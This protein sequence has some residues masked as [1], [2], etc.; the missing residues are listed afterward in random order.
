MSE[1]ITYVP[2][3]LKSILTDRW[4][5]KRFNNRD[6]YVILQ[7]GDMAVEIQGNML[8]IHQ[9]AISHVQENEA[10]T[11]VIYEHHCYLTGVFKRELQA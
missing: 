2:P 1:Q 7:T 3:V 5:H 6:G 11:A 10:H 8:D 4:A 9:Q